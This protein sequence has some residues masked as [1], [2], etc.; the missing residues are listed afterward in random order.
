MSDKCL[1]HTT[2]L[3]VCTL[4][5]GAPKNEPWNLESAWSKCK[6]ADSPTAPTGGGSWAALSLEFDL[7]A[8]F[9]AVGGVFEEE[10]KSDLFLETDAVKRNPALV[11]DVPEKTAESARRLVIRHMRRSAVG[12]G[13]NGVC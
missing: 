3:S 6:K 4:P 11:K 13:K 7:G 5:N 12:L 9:E 10:E 2:W 1:T 8:D